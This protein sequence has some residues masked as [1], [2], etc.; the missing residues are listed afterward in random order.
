[1]QAIKDNAQRLGLTWQIQYATVSDGAS[2]GA[3][4]VMFDGDSL[5]VPTPAVSLV[6]A[7]TA[8]QR[9]AV[10][11]TPPDGA[12][13]IGILRSTPTSGLIVQVSAT[14]STGAIG[15]ET[16]V[17]TTALAP[18]V[19]GRAYEARMLGNWVASAAGNNGL[20]KCRISGGF[21]IAVDQRTPTLPAAGSFVS[22]TQFG[23]FQVSPS[24]DIS[25]DET[26]AASAGTVTD[27]ASA[28]T[29]RRLSIWDIGAAS[30]FTNLVSI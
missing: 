20:V 22:A 14:T 4:I 8:G 11:T 6:G 24:R 25:F 28:G 17:L 19:A 3:I 9:V 15:A 1:V 16:A 21:A 27:L 18:F 7:L 10:L 2:A 5:S 29:P 13:V 26:L 12:Y 30:E 23:Q